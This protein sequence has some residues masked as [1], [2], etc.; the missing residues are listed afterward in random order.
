MSIEEKHNERSHALSDYS[1]LLRTRSSPEIC[2]KDN[3]L[4]KRKLKVPRLD[5]FS[6]NEAVNNKKILSGN[7]ESLHDISAM[8]VVSLYQNDH[9]LEDMDTARYEF[10]IF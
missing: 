2:S 3:A 7:N 6:Q 9:S 8:S 4:L 5:S 10:K 1:P